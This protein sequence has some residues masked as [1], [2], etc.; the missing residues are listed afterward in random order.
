MKSVGK[1]AD[2]EELAPNRIR[3]T[4]DFTGEG[5]EWKRQ[6]VLSASDDGKTLV[7]RELGDDAAPGPFQYLRCS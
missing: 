2:V 4:F 6:Q 7:R 3:A 1:L 5:L